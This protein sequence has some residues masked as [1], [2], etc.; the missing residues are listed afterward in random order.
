MFRE[1]CQNLNA[2][3]TRQSECS[4]LVCDEGTQFRSISGCCNNIAN[5]DLGRANRAFVRITPTAYE[6]S[7]SIPRG[8]MHPSNIPNP[9]AV[10]SGVHRVQ[11][12]KKLPPISVMLMQ[13]GQFL[14]HDMTLTPE[15]GCLK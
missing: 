11:G 10:S 7:I 4:A 3:I 2:D 8:G 15:Q 5:K 14:D 9:R 12:N 1:T 13:F 6:D